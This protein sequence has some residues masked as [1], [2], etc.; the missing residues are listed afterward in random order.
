METVTHYVED[1][2]SLLNESSL[3]EKR[4][5]IRSFVKEVKVTGNQVLLT[6]TIPM[7]S[8]GL[9]EEELGVPSIVHYGGAGGIRTPYLLNA[10]QALSQLSYSP[11]IDINILL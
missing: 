9:I 2:R 4:S 1:L 8:K 11:S 5:F 7:S 10:I 6:Y 3:T